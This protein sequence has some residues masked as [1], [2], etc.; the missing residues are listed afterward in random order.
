MLA[1]SRHRGRGRVKPAA[2]LRTRALWAFVANDAP[3][4]SIEGRTVPSESPVPGQAP[5]LTAGPVGR[6]Q[7]SRSAS[8]GD[9]RAEV[10]D[11]VIDLARSCQDRGRDVQHRCQSRSPRPL[12]LDLRSRGSAPKV[13]C[14]PFHQILA[15]VRQGNHAGKALQRGDQPRSYRAMIATRRV[16]HDLFSSGTWRYVRGRSGRK[17]FA[18]TRWIDSLG[19]CA[20]HDVERSGVPPERIISAVAPRRDG[21]SRLP[22][23]PHRC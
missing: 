12:L 9:R 21:R 17:A 3:V 14:G 23:P 19:Y 13:G 1:H 2:A 6:P 4:G 15:Q 22:A 10:V 7:I 18:S 16:S 8:L 5:S 20:R 11:V